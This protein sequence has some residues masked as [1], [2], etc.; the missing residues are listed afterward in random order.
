MLHMFRFCIFIPLY[1][2]NKESIERALRFSK[3]FDI[4]IFYNT[5]GCSLSSIFKHHAVEYHYYNYNFGLSYPS[6]MCFLRA[7]DLG[8]T[9]C[10]FLDQD[11]SVNEIFIKLCI[12]E[13]KYIFNNFDDVSVCSFDNG[14][15]ISD[16]TNVKLIRNSG[17]VFDLRH[18]YCTG[19]FNT[20][21]FVDLI[22]YDYSF[23]SIVA[24]KKLL[25]KTL[26]NLFDHTSEQDGDLISIF[27]KPLLVRNY[28]STRFNDINSNLLKLLTRSVISLR[29]DFSI[30]FFK[31]LLS[32]FVIKLISKLRFS[33]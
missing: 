18:F 31:S 23:R 27:G 3:S 10:L 26:P 9:H 25:L 2:P 16:F 13:S 20:N 17:S 32:N 11:T 14:L 4:F 5:P 29:L 12:D 6:N 24:G 30:L 1:Y 21:L 28:H 33:F 7:F 15:T 22:D 19:G 8:Y